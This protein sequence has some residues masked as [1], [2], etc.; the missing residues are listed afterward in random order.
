MQEQSATGNFGVSKNVDQKGPS[1]AASSGRSLCNDLGTDPSNI[2]RF[3]RNDRS[4]LVEVCFERTVV[5]A[6]LELQNVGY[7]GRLN[8]RKKRT[9]PPEQY[10]KPIETRSKWMLWKCYLILPKISPS[11][12]NSAKLQADEVR[13]PSTELAPSHWGAGPFSTAPLHTRT[14]Q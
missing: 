13:M 10:C 12:A 2:A 1:E 9:S 3:S 5:L 4:R 7:L 8:A 14:K 6:P 11:T